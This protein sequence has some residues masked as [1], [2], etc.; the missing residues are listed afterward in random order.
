MLEVRNDGTIVDSD[1]NIELP[2]KFRANGFAYV[3]YQGKEYQVHRLVASKYLEGF[4]ENS[5]VQH[6]DGDKTNNCVANLTLVS[7]G[8]I[9]NAACGE[10]HGSSKMTENT[11]R[12]FREQYARGASIL[13]LSRQF[14][15]S[16]AAAYKIAKNQTWIGV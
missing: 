16:Y 7:R 1:K 13:S 14:D 3:R 6:I 5:V 9:N 11:V 4:D 10:H 2:A 12:L 8:E 15:I